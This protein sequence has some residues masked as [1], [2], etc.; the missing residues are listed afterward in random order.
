MIEKI[1]KRNGKEEDFS[2]SKINGWGEWA[3][4]TLNGHVDWGSVVI[5]AVN[6]SPK[7]CSSLELQKRLID[8]CLSRQTWEYNKMAGRLYAGLIRREI[9][10]DGMPTLKEA[11][12]KMIQDGL[13][14]KMDYSDSDYEFIEKIID[15]K[16]DFKYPHYQ[17]NQIRLKY[18]LR[19]K[20]DGIEYETP[21]MVFA[22]MAMSLSENEPRDRLIHVSK[23]Y[24]HFSHAR[25]NAPTPNY[26]NLGTKLNGYASCA[27]YTTDDNAASLAAGDHIAYMMTCASAGIGTHIKT[28]SLRDPVRCGLIVH[29]GKLPY[30]RALVGAIGANLQ[31]G[32]GGAST[33]HYSA[34][35]P[36]VEVIQ[37]LRHPMTPEAKRIAGCHYSFGSNKLFARKVAKNETFAPFSYY[38]NEEMFEAQYEQDQSK[39]EQLYAEYEKTA[40]V[41]ISAR[42]VAISALQQA[43]ETGVHYLHFFDQLNS[44]TPFKEKI[45]S[46]NLC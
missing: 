10:P 35:D 20:V 28:R 38:G 25:L 9:Y 30:Y 2:P 39:F 31:N 5:E 21:Q 7:I 41:K 3:A 18:A 23:Y 27:L 37:K 13:M 44:H 26:V 33:V 40:K 43:Y 4:K 24:E 29:Q 15:H 16:M 34:F 45:Y 11:H 32:R 19:N 17:L 14:V 46:S 36:E 12:E 22:R 42:E 8:I 6:T 1:I